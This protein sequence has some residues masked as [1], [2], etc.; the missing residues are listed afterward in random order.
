[1]KKFIGIIIVLAVI[2]GILLMR[3]SSQEVEQEL[4][5]TESQQMTDNAAM[6]DDMDES[7]DDVVM[8]D[9]TTYSVDG[10]SA[11]YQVQKEFFGK[12]AE[13][14]VG[15][16]DT[17][18][19]T[20]LVSSSD[21]VSLDLTIGADFVTGS[22]ARDNEITRLLGETMHVAAKNVRVPGVSTSGSV[23]FS[24]PVTLTING[25]STLVEFT[26]QGSVSDTAIAGNGEA[27]VSIAGLGVEAPS[28][29][30]VYTVDDTVVLG[31]EFTGSTTE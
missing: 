13:T 8:A 15:T 11:Y 23:S 5:D 6:S 18:T 16:T 28:A 26:V 27:V 3:D 1:M 20:I 10:G 24:I 25:Q 30:G 22:N 17:V 19:G 9:A 31:I 12:D 7:A 2:I 21:M 29:A 4:D 14:V